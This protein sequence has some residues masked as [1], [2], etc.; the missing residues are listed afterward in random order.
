MSSTFNNAQRYEDLINYYTLQKKN[1]LQFV[2]SAKMQAD[3]STLEKVESTFLTDVQEQYRNFGEPSTIANQVLNNLLDTKSGI[4]T[5]QN[6]QIARNTAKDA[7]QE[8]KQLIQQSTTD[9][10]IDL[11][12]EINQL[13]DESWNTFISSTAT[14]ATW[15]SA[16][17]NQLEDSN[18]KQI[19]NYNLIRANL[20]NYLKKTYITRII[21]FTGHNP[22]RQRLINRLAGYYRENLIAM[23]LQNYLE[24]KATVTLQGNINQIE[25]ILI[26]WESLNGSGQSETS[27]IGLQSKSW[28]LPSL[29][30]DFEYKA[31]SINAQYFYSIASNV[32]LQQKFI[33]NSHLKGHSWKENLNFF[34]LE[35]NGKDALGANNILYLVHDQLLF[36]S[37]LIK[38]MREKDFYISFVFEF[39]EWL[40]TSKITWQQYRMVKNYASHKHT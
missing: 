1:F 29:D 10:E 4:L 17:K 21:H 28:I 37:E 8:Y 20:M 40:A 38:A 25:D 16:L 5:R 6:L 30:K 3:Q 27:V 33:T 34:N 9:V 24:G 23:A 12:K 19:G 14:G 32:N 15:I 35:E 18:S 26:S 13:I 2:E 7:R 39:P 11:Q 22:K 31:N 36:T